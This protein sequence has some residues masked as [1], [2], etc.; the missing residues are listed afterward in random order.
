MHVIGLLLSLLMNEYSFKNKNS[1][2]NEYSFK[3]WVIDATI[4]TESL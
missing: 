2:K 1:F 4:K 3:K